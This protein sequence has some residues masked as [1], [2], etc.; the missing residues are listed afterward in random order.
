[1]SLTEQQKEQRLNF[2]TGSDAAVICGVSPW[3]NI[4]D[5]WREKCRLKEQ[6][7]ISDLP[8]VKAGIMLEPAVANWFEHETGKLCEIDTNFQIHKSIPWMGGN[9]DRRITGEDAILECKTSSNAAAWGA[10]GDNS[11]PDYYLCQVAH[12]S[13]VCDIE[14]AYVAVLLHGKD[15]RWYT[16]ERNIKLE[17]KLI[18]KEREFWE[19]V[20]NGIPP[21]PRTNAEIISLY[22][23]STSID[24]INAHETIEIVCAQLKSLKAEIKDLD[25][26]KEEL[27]AIIK[28][29]M[30]DKATLLS[31]DGTRKLATWSNARGAIRFDA[32]A[33]A[34]DQP[35]LY[36]F[37]LRQHKPTRKFLIK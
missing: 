32:N 24:P 30:K 33:L 1:M 9:I 37:Y 15:F 34:K 7:D 21:T 6:E 10:D 36:S 3:G 11:I 12:Y 17:E 16:Y 22:T 23:Q 19:C 28:G 25:G 29:Y 2:I 31:A 35:T 4:I 26:R 13:A 14:R 27:E 20:Q 18:E 5:L 8:H